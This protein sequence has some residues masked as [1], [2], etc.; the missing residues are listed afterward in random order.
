MKT[1]TQLKA[2][3]RNLAKE[4]NIEAQ[5]ILRNYMLERLLERISVSKYKENFILKGGMLIAAMV[6]LHTRSTMDMDTTL[7]G[8][9]LSEESVRT[10]FTEILQ[11][12]V[13]DDVVMS[14]ENIEGIHDEAD[15]PG[16]RVSIGAVLDKTRQVLKVD[17]TTGDTITPHEVN[18]LFR[19][20]FGGEDIEI[21]AYSLETVL[22]EKMET[23]LSRS[24]TNTRMRDFYDIYILTTLQS[25]NIDKAVLLEAFR[26]TVEKRGTSYLLENDILQALNTIKSSSIM[27][28][29][30]GRYQKRF[31]YAEDISWG[32]VMNTTSNIFTQ[33]MQIHSPD[34]EQN[35]GAGMSLI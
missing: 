9:T 33:E 16:L 3:I 30:W 34:E 29:L 4:K 25:K 12:S 11:T 6:G 1:S 23:I 22:A 17:I 28:E 26:K 10:I 2:L 15:Y 24:T 14:L 5:I 18:Y 7:K 20:L 21:K 8:Q 27:Q 32:T 35:G 13:N 19:P 31:S